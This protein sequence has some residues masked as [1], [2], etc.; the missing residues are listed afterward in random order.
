MNE[1]GCGGPSAL[2]GPPGTGVRA[3]PHADPAG[4]CPSGSFRPRR[5]CEVRGFLRARVDPETVTGLALT[6][7]LL[8]V[9]VAAV[10]FGVVVTM[11][12]RS[13]AS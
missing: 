6:L 9:L 3:L 11:I 12:R 7:A 5:A 13:W 2:V 8:A 4:S 10:V 1:G